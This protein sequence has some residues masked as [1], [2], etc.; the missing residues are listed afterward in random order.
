[1]TI[2][3]F[4]ADES[5]DV[6]FSFE[7]GASRYFVVVA[8]C[9]EAPDT[10]RQSISDFRDRSGLPQEYEFKF[11]RVTTMTLRKRVFSMLAEQDFECW[12]V[13]VDKT[14]L[15]DTFRVMQGLE[16][17]LYFVSE[18]IGLIPGTQREHATLILDEFGSAKQTRRELRRVLKARDV[19]PGFHQMRTARSR[20]ESLLQVAD[21]VAGAISHRDAKGPFEAYDLISSKIRG[22]L[23]YRG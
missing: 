11:S 19:S 1:M 5:G 23:E 13:I 7:K 20:S 8:I 4:A 3:T 6:S 15:A 17:Y 16:V 14:T 2:Y 12:A 9:T 18:L 22:A 21:L 10:L